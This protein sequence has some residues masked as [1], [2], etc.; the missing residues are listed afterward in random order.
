M[1]THPYRLGSIASGLALV[2]LVSLLVAADHS[3]AQGA[4]GARSGLPGIDA[5]DAFVAGCVDC[6]V[7]L[8][9]RDVRIGPMLAAL[10]HPSVGRRVE[11]VPQ[12]CRKCHVDEGSA[13]PLRTLVHRAHYGRE[14][15]NHFIQEFG[16]LCLHCHAVDLSSGEVRVKQGSKNW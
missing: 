6:H 2:F 15:E 9:D 8:P 5:E 13:E 16:G 7:E 11:T 12:D 10:D 4:T 1:M 3:A 14:G